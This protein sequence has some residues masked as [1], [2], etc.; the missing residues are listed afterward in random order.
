MRYFILLFLF[1]SCS[2]NNLH[3]SN[4]KLL[5]QIIIEHDKLMLEMKNIKKIKKDLIEKEEDFDITEKIKN[6]DNARMSMMNFMEEFSQEFSFENYPM[7][8]EKY[9]NLTQSELKAVNDK[10]IEFKNSIGNSNS[11]HS[12]L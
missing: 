6:L 11:K 4:I 5:D 7:N 8:K 3:N 2:N 1:F 10:L 12:L 9:K